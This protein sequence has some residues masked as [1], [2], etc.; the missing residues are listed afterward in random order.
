VAGY[1]PVILEGLNKWLLKW[2]DDDFGQVEL[3]AGVGII[4]TVAL[5]KLAF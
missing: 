4:V 5:S 1:L 3:W 2:T